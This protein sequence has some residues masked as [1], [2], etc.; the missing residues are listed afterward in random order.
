MC[1]CALR[2]TSCR[3]RRGVAAH[4]ALSGRCGRI[5]TL[6]AGV[7]PAETIAKQTHPAAWTSSIRRQSRRA[8][9]PSQG[10]PTA[11]PGMRPAATAEGR[12]HTAVCGA[13]ACVHLYH[14]A[15]C[16]GVLHCTHERKQLCQAVAIEHGDCKGDDGLEVLQLTRRGETH[17]PPCERR[18]TL[19]SL[20]RRGISPTV[21]GQQN[22]SLQLLV[23]LP[24]CSLADTNSIQQQYKS[25]HWQTQTA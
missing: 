8:E 21:P 25:C 2:P 1:V 17:T 16:A 14:R 12:Q 10:T 18:D 15:G 22:G 24:S 7:L 20:D 13:I 11:G 23:Q 3:V 6:C 19:A 4:A 5:H 9:S